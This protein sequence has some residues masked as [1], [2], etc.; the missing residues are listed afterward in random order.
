[1]RTLAGAA[2]GVTVSKHLFLLAGVSSLC[3]FTA[4]LARAAD[5]TAA[6]ASSADSTVGEVVVTADKAGLLERRPNN[7]AMG[8]D[9]PLIETP[10][11]ASLISDTTLQRYGIQTIDKLTAVSPGTYTAS[12]YGV[13]GSLNIRGTLA[14]NY[15]MGFKR[16]ENRG[17]YSTPIGDA[18]QIEIVRGPPAPIYGPGK[19]G[20]LMNFIPK[21]SKDSGAYITEP[22]GEVDIVAGDYGKKNFSAQGGVPLHLG[23]AQGGLYG[24]GEVE[25]SDSYYWGIHPQHQLAEVSA[26]FDL[27]GG[28]ST[29]LMGMYFHSTG[30]VQT[31]GWN[32]LTQALIDHRTYITGRNTA[33][34][35]SNGNGRLDPCEVQL[36]GYCQYPYTMAIYTPYFG[37]TP[38]TD[39]RYPLTTG[40]GTTTLSPHD[41]YVSNADFSRTN[42][43]TLYYELAKQLTG[44]ST[45]KLQWFY[46]RLSNARFVSYGFPA[47]YHAWTTEGRLTYNFKLAFD[48]DF[49][50]A[51]SFAGLSWRYYKGNQKETYDSGMIAL[52]RRDLSVGATPTDILASPFDPGSGVGWETDIYSHWHDTGL[53][54]TTDIAVADKLDIIAG[55]RYDWYGVWAIDKGLYSFETPNAVSASK[56]KFTYTISGTYKLGWGLMPYI[57]H[58]EN[59]SLE[60][61]QAGDLRPS[62][63][64]S[65]AWLTDSNLTE[66]GVK[67]QFLNKTLVG[68]LA[69]YQQERTQL[70]GLSSIVQ[71]TRSKG[72]EYEVRWVATK[73]L[74]FTLAGNG[75]RTEVIG[76]DHSFVYIP[77]YTVGV[78]GV[79]GYGGAFVTFDFSTLPGRSGNYDYSLIPHSVVSF[80]TTYTT[81]DYSW[82]H[83]GATAGFTYA[84]KTS[85]L[86]QNAVT[87]PAYTVVNASLL[88]AKG[89][90]EVDFNV[91]NLF[92]KLY[93]TPDQDTYANVGAIPSIGRTWRFTFKGKF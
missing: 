16:I 42:T 43:E 81:D 31:P 91:D 39:A 6:G 26:N 93:F 89:P 69:L 71:R 46:D 75:Q 73:N 62:N 44:D 77:A 68:S 66:G 84:S 55:G 61:E 47:D 3:L 25:D 87:Y 38:T 53:F 13:P 50:V 36:P 51:K 33:L 23:A 8:L 27:G 79:D 67:F 63:I 57:T 4:G 86:V 2:T 32:R 10:R 22:T 35:D 54:F 21:T 48:N 58:A 82:G 78:N 41:V 5:A 18:A 40:V 76:P 85:G 30:D 92:D 83:A 59:A 28:W 1:M 20:G 70:S 17:T 29:A 72:F 7:T 12:Y 14:E 60:V 52:D 56:G 45:L 19:I 80:F 15:F 34:V 90:Y 24:Y 65:G 11:S 74:S 64:Q 49:I 9:K 37:F 88:W